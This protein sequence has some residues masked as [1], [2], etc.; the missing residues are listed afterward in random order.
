MR[1]KPHALITPHRSDSQKPRDDP[2]VTYRLLPSLQALPATVSPCLFI[3]AVTGLPPPPP[4]DDSINPLDK[5][6]D[7][8]A[9]SL[10]KE[11]RARQILLSWNPD[12]A[13]G[14]DMKGSRRGKNEENVDVSCGE[15]APTQPEDIKREEIRRSEERIPKP[16][17]PKDS[18]GKKK[19][20]SDSFPQ[21]V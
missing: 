2:K 7:H 11:E 3:I 8:N 16:A 4:S 12:R 19:S 5:V 15:G 18:A 9:P 10:R 1:I 6:L 14:T 13:L 20:Q 17:V 21:R